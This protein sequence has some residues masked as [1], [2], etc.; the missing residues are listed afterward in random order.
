MIHS[1]QIENFKS[2]KKQINLDFEVD[3]KAPATYKYLPSYTEK[4]RV[5]AAITFIGPNASGKTSILE[6]LIFIQWLLTKSF[7]DRHD[8]EDMYSPFAT[9]TY[10]K[11]PTKLSVAFEVKKKLYEYKV[12][13]L[14]NKIL[15]EKLS[16]RTKA[17]VRLSSRVLLRRKWDDAKKSYKSELK[18]TFANI[19]FTMM[20]IDEQLS[21][22]VIAVGNKFGNKTSREITKYWNR[23]ATNVDIVTDAFFMYD[24]VARSAMRTSTS[25]AKERELFLNYI[26]RFDSG[27]D[28]YDRKNHMF[29]HK[30][31]DGEVLELPVERQSS[32]TKQL[33]VLASKLQSVLNNGGIAIIDEFD[34]YLH[35]LWL[36]EL[37][38]QFFDPTKNKH[39]AQVIMSTHSIQ[40]LGLLDKYQIFISEKT[41]DKTDVYRVDD[42]E[43][44][45]ADDNY[46]AKYMSGK[47]G[48][49]PNFDKD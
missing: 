26:K 11:K 24:F 3:N 37:V 10:K 31:V 2:I 45:R 39:G 47:L 28:D 7:D 1:L 16:V 36:N 14:E 41:E 23:I 29:K 22:T 17:S 38:S 8:V 19:P 6:S 33:I 48:G 20:D 44:I 32:G 40:I 9:A 15:Y 43:G 13:C 4:N 42:I 35:P 46:Y 25:N 49:I 34:A 21:T 18:D 27:I 5:S 12:E 30:T